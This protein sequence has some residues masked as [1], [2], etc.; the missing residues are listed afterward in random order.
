MAQALPAQAPPWVRAEGGE[1]LWIYGNGAGIHPQG[2]TPYVDLWYVSEEAGGWQQR[3]RWPEVLAINTAIEPDPGKPLGSAL[4][5]YS[6]GAE[7]A[8]ERLMLLGSFLE[9]KPGYSPSAGPL[10][11]AKVG[12]RISSFHFEWQEKKGV[13]ESKPVGGGW[14]QFE[15]ENFAMQTLALNGFIYV[16]TFDASAIYPIEGTELVDLEA[17]HKDPTMNNS[18]VHATVR[19]CGPHDLH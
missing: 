16:Y 8:G 1:T 10:E 19:H 11:Q 17:Q 15:G 9:W 5:A 6:D 3:L 13:W 12:N 14:Q 7:R 4:V 2:G 18:G